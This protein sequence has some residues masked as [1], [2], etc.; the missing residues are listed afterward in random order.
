[1]KIM[2]GVEL[3]DWTVVAA[4]AVVTKSFPDGYTTLAGIPA[5]PIEKLTQE[6]CVPFGVAKRY[7]GYLSEA[8]FGKIWNGNT[9]DQ[10]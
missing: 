6:Q 9:V 1:V 5:K 8:E 2:P 7:H 4:G 10:V 3:G